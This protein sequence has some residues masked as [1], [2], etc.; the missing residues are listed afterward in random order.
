MNYPD[1][2]QHIA[3]SLKPGHCGQWQIILK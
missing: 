1:F 2:I 3:H